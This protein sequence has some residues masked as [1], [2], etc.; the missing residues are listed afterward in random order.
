ML[1]VTT[2]IFP[3]GMAEF[4]AIVRAIGGAAVLAGIRL[5]RPPSDPFPKV[6]MDRMCALG[7]H[8]NILWAIV[9]RVLVNVVSHLVR[10]QITAKFH[11][12]NHAMLQLPHVWLCNFDEPV[13]VVLHPTPYG[14]ALSV[15]PH[16]C[17]IAQ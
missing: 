4:M 14:Y 16:R 11:R 13:T 15:S 2:E 8:L 1:P 10:E 17:S 6:V 7:H 12:G 3:T 5:F 9:E